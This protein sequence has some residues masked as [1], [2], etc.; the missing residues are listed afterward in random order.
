MYSRTSIVVIFTA[1]KGRIE[2]FFTIYFTLPFITFMELCKLNLEKR[3]IDKEKLKLN[4]NQM[5]IFTYHII[6]HSGSRVV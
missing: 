2:V 1:R 3:Q 6:I 5:F 4:D